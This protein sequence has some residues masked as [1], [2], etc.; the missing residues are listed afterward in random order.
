MTEQ[1]LFTLSGARGATGA[2]GA[3]GPTGPGVPSNLR[4]SSAAGITVLAGDYIRF[5]GSTPR[6]W[7]I[8]A[9]ANSSAPTGRMAIKNAASV[10]LTLNRSGADTFFTDS[11]VTS[12]TLVPGEL[13][14]LINTG[15][16]WDVG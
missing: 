5:T 14:E 12:L 13:V 15:S 1:V 11:A 9:A 16:G 7:T 2:T 10:D 3:T 6:T 4:T 8:D